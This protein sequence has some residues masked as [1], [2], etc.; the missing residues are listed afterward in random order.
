MIIPEVEGR[1]TAEPT[2][3]ERS[4]SPTCSVAPASCA[5][6]VRGG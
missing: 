1:H 5:A 6:S 4:T 3:P 2:R